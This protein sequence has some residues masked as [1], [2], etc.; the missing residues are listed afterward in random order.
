MS[1]PMDYCLMGFFAFLVV[2]V[3]H[4]NAAWGAPFEQNYMVE[5]GSDHI[6]Y[7]EGHTQVQLTLDQTSGSGFGSKAGYGSGFFQMRIKLPDKDTTRIIA[8]FYI[9]SVTSI[10]DEID[11]EFLGGNEIFLLHTNVFTNGVGGREQ[12][13]SFWFDPTAD[14]H[15]YKILWN[16]HQIVLFVDETPLRVFK[17]ITDSGVGYPTQPMRVEGTI[18]SADWA[19]NGKPVNWSSAPFQANYQWFG[20]DGCQAQTLNPQQCHS[21][22]LFW[23]GQKFWDLDANQR[24]AYENVRNKF[25]KYDY[26]LDR[27]RYPNVPPECQVNG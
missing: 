12:Q 4:A 27:A 14:F 21:P 5:Y 8:T 25:L 15:T 26:C 18:W 24:K 2:F 13:F 20:I 9:I 19:S 16:E 11:F 17:N 3:V 1:S 6:Q 23:N 10:H 22:D 7:F